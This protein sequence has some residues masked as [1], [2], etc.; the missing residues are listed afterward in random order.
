[1]SEAIDGRLLAVPL[2][3]LPEV[4]PGDDLGRLA[5]EAWW[6][7]TTEDP[8]LAPQSGDVLVATQKIVSKA[9]GRIVRLAVEMYDLLFLYPDYDVATLL[10]EL[11]DQVR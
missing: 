7:L 4:R 11:R 6:R 9:E 8:A 3:P 2:P 1:M 5:A 10:D